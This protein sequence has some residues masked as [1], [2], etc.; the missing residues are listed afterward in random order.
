M[1]YSIQLYWKEQIYIFIAVAI[2]NSEDGVCSYATRIGGEG[3]T[4]WKKVESSTK[5]QL[6]DCL[7]IEYSL[8]NN[9]DKSYAAFDY[10]VADENPFC[11]NFFFLSFVSLFGYRGPSDE[12]ARIFRYIQYVDG[13]K[14]NKF[15]LP[16][17]CSTLYVRTYG[18][19]SSNL[20][21]RM[22]S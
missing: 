2:L 3:E 13:N 20:F 11:E 14:N 21:V 6:K 7:S 18:I 10:N 8:G 19:R 9:S 17:M 22:P 12:R 5:L 1:L 4:K 15:F 16:S